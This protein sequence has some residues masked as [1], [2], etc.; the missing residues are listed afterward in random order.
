MHFIIDIKRKT[1]AKLI[2]V[3]VVFFAHV[4]ICKAQKVEISNT[5]IDDKGYEFAKVLGHNDDGFYLLQSNLSLAISNNRIGFKVRKYR[6]IYMDFDMNI[7]WQHEVENSIDKKR[8]A[9][10]FFFNSQPMLV[11]AEQLPNDKYNVYCVNMFANGNVMFGDK[12]KFE[13]TLP[14]DEA[15]DAINGT[16]S[17]YDEKFCLLLPESNNDNQK[18]HFVIC[19]TTLQNYVLRDIVINQDDNHFVADEFDVSDNGDVALSGILSADKKIR[20]KKDYENIT[21][22]T[23]L[24]TAANKDAMIYDFKVP[25]KNIGEASILFDNDNNQLV[26]GG[27]YQTADDD[28]KHGI[29]YARYALDKVEPAI[30]K[31]FELNNATTGKVVDRIE[32]NI[33]SVAGYTI[34]KIVLRSDSGAIIVAEDFYKEEYSFY[35]YFTQTVQRRFEYHYDNMMVISINNDGSTDWNKLIRKE[36]TSTNDDAVFLSYIS[37]ATTGRLY[38]IYNRDISL[39]NE[40]ISVAIDNKG[41]LLDS[42][43]LRSL[44]H[45]IIMPKYGKQVAPNELILPVIQKKKMRLAK[46]TF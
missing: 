38:F 20:N 29:A 5:A 14:N 16:A 27:F 15:F 10:V 11:Y 37:A 42:D 19:D 36:Q 18:Y 13:I 32:E 9:E 26:V 45:V 30:I 43:L 1:L 8:L 39:N 7:K 34:S 44:D 25:Q 3:N 46:I 24:I 21:Y 28:A 17:F 31:C 23:Y 12:N 22:S 6:L 35:D 41:K 40:V 4:F 33:S 2:L